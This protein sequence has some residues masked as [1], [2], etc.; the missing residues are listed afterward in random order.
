[1]ECV[2]FHSIIWFLSATMLSNKVAHLSLLTVRL[3]SVIKKIK[4]VS[5]LHDAV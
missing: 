4:S 2:V 5:Y 1:M 3:M